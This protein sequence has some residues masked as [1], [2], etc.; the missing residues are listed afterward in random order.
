[1][2]LTAVASPPLVWLLI[3][4]SAPS[5]CVCRVSLC[6]CACAWACCV[7]DIGACVC[8]YAFC[9]CGIVPQHSLSTARDY[10]HACLVWQRS[11]PSGHRLLRRIH[12]QVAAPHP[13]ASQ[14]M[15]CINNIAPL[16]SKC[17]FLNGAI[18]G[19]EMC[20]APSALNAGSR[21][22][23]PKHVSNP[24][25]GSLTPIYCMVCVLLVGPFNAHLLYGLGS[26]SRPI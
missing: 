18:S 12:P 17:F 3:R 16:L 25:Q 7:C 14:S 15:H 10:V 20:F 4:A 6:A 9:V 22:S 23:Q 5:V 2:G 11:S 26:T 1:M 21:R 24:A 19:F 8:A 13:R